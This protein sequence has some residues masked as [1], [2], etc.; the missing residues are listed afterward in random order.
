M[1]NIFCFVLFATASTP[2][3][4]SS[5][6]NDTIGLKRKKNCAARADIARVYVARTNR[7]TCCTLISAVHALTCSAKNNNDNLLAIL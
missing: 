3:K 6:F 2:V 4:R 5:N 1:P 7:R